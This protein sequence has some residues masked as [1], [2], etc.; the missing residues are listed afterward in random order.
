MFASESH[1][2]ELV[3]VEL[4]D[5]VSLVVHVARDRLIPAARYGCIEGR[6]SPPN[7]LP[8]RS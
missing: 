5:Q 7:S 1:C 3:P 6:R 2:L 4:C 8:Q